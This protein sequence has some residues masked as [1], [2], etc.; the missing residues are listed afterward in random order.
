MVKS[1]LTYTVKESEKKTFTSCKIIAS[2]SMTAQPTPEQIITTFFNL[3]NGLWYY[4]PRTITI[5]QEL[6]KNNILVITI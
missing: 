5:L 6:L 1:Y 3:F 4:K 2:L